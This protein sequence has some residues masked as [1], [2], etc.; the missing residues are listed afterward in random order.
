LQA[1]I[2]EKEKLPAKPSNIELSHGFEENN[3]QPVPRVSN[4]PIWAAIGT[5]IMGGVRIVSSLFGF[6]PCF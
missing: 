5:I 2:L 3:I 1:F 6:V 4:M